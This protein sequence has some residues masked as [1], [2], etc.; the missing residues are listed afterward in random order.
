VL[1]DQQHK[2]F[3]ERGYLQLSD[4]VDSGQVAL[5]R[6]RIWDE[7]NSRGALR[8]DQSTWPSGHATNFTR[9]RK[10]DPDPL[11]ND[12]LRSAISELINRD[13]KL[14]PD[15]RQAL[16]TFPIES[17]WRVPGANWH[18]DHQRPDPIKRA[19]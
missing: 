15:W 9:I 12:S 10:S 17:P 1:S 18:L 14:R 8:D 5:M 3:F 2:Q 19:A 7:M 13:W 4:A 11:E 6:D 16:V